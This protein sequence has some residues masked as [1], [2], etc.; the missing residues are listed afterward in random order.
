MRRNILMPQLHLLLMLLLSACAAG[1]PGSTPL[2]TLTPQPGPSPLP[3]PTSLP[4]ATASP[5][6][7]A[8]ALPSATLLPTAT[9][10]PTATATAAPTTTPLPPPAPQFSF[11]IGRPGEVPGSGFF[12]RHAYAVENTWFNPGHWHTGEDWYAVAGDT[13][14]AEIY[15]VAAGEVVYAGSNYPGRVVIVRHSEE[16][17]SMYGHLDPALAVASGEPVARGQL[18]GTV[19][20]RSDTVPNHLHFELRTFL[21]TPEVNGATPRY[22]FRCGVHCLPGPGYWPIGAPDHPGA[23]GWRNPSHIIGGRMFPADYDGALGTVLVPPGAPDRLTLHE[24]PAADAP[25]VL[26]IDISAGQRFRLLEVQT[27]P[28]DSRDTGAAAYSLWYRIAVA[29]GIVGW[30]PALL[31]SDFETGSNGAPA[32][33]YWQLLPE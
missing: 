25:A 15:A 3:D 8:S 30:S 6:A 11:P 10:A 26:N 33:L 13:A 5:T 23:R 1:L 31:V 22:G 19:L 12:I 14:G 17:Y 4:W 20:R 16:L 9:P 24:G 27:G 21:T 2:P 18:L 28:A 7:T 29:D 32:T